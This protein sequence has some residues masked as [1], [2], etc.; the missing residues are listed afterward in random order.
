MQEA[1]PCFQVEKMHVDLL[2]LVCQST[3]L[4]RNTQ[5]GACRQEELWSTKPWLLIFVFSFYCLP[6]LLTILLT[7]KCQF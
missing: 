6:S 2:T 4:P 7:S 5:A 3:S 1:T